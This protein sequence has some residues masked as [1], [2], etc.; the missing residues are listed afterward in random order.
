MLLF[1]HFGCTGFK[2]LHQ[3]CHSTAQ[4]STDM[5]FIQQQLNLDKGLFLCGKYS[6]QHSVT[7]QFQC[8]ALA[9]RTAVIVH[10]PDLVVH[11][12]SVCSC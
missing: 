2:G 9:A 11:M 6:S 5:Q 8:F 7:A 1:F 4:Q 3:M 12:G 10:A